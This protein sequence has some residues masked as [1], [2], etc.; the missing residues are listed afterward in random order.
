MPEFPETFCAAQ[1]GLPAWNRGKPHTRPVAPDP[2]RKNINRRCMT[3]RA[4]RGIQIEQS[5]FAGTFAV[6]FAAA[7]R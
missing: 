3:P 5:Y 1:P 7:S 4:M 2:A 6:I